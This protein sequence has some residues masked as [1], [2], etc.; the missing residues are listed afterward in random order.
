MVPSHI[1]FQSCVSVNENLLN[2]KILR[3]S[4]HSLLYIRYSNSGV[5]D[6]YALLAYEVG[7][8]ESV[9]IPASVIGIILI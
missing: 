2:S 1:R 3:T 6:Y 7:G 5:F 9:M 8:I 4:R